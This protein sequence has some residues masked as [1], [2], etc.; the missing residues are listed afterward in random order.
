MQGSIAFNVTYDSAIAY[1]GCVEGAI[2]VN[3]QL[4][5]SSQSSSQSGTG[6]ISVNLQPGLTNR[7]FK[8]QKCAT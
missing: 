7:D 3:T 1:S 4:R 6:A 8:W 2:N 5:L